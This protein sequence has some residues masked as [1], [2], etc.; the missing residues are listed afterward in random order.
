MQV[1]QKLGSFFYTYTQCTKF[2]F[3]FLFQGN[4][5]NIREFFRFSLPSRRGE[6]GRKSFA[7]SDFIISTAVEGCSYAEGAQRGSDATPL[8]VPARGGVQFSNKL[9]HRP[10]EQL[11]RAATRKP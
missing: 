6:T 2:S 7:L 8:R 10:R 4:L 11:S 9:H 1:A 3:N 5:G